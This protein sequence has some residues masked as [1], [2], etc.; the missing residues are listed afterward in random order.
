MTESTDRLLREHP[1]VG[2][3][4]Y[5]FTTDNLTD[6]HTVPLSLNGSLKLKKASCTACNNITSKF[7]RSVSRDTLKVA[8]AVMQ[9]TT[10]HPERR[11][12]TYPVEVV[13]SGQVQTVDMP[14]EAYAALVPLIDLGYPS[15]LID[16]YSL[17]S[18]YR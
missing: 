11:R 9:Y 6:E 15:H 13:I 14:V 16:K 12:E 1:V 2:R 8:R 7:E 18:E 17:G 3:C 10:R 4:I 5:C